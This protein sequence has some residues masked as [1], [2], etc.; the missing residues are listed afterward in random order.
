MKVLLSL[1]LLLSAFSLHA[2][3]DTVQMHKSDSGTAKIEIESEFPGGLHAWAQYLVK[4]LSYP[5]EA[6]RSHVQG[7]VVVKFVVE[8]DGKVTDVHAVSGPMELREAAVSLIKHSPK[9]IP[10]TQDGKAVK[11]YKSQPISYRTDQ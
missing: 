5:D 9:W 8:V 3:S 4:N 6:S 7:I 10:A 1:F 11:S 2:Q